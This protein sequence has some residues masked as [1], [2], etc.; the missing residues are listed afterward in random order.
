M[1]FSWFM[2]QRNAPISDPVWSEGAGFVFTTSTPTTDLFA[3]G[4]WWDE[5]ATKKPAPLPALPDID[6]REPTATPLSAT[7]TALALTFSMTPTRTP[8]F[9][10]NTTEPAATYTPIKDE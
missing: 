1:V 7:Q 10:I 6:L 2:N 8:L 9:D 5:M 3:E 4:G